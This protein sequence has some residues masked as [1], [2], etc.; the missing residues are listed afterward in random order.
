MV[1][2]F[3]VFQVFRISKF[4]QTQVAFKLKNSRVMNKM[5]LQ[6]AMP[7]ETFATVR[8]A[9]QVIAT[10]QAFMQAQSAGTEHSLRTN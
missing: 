3:V 4:T 1:L 7:R 2:H 9:V 8:T 10:M 5:P 6:V